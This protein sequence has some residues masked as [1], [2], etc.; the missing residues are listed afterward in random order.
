[1]RYAPYVATFGEYADA[2][3]LAGLA[4]DAEE[5]GW[6]GFF[7]WD[8]MAMWWD[9]ASPVVDSWVALAAI[10]GATSTIRIGALVTPVPRRR[11]WKLARES[12]SID[13]LS[14]GRLVFGAGLGANRHEF[15]ELGEVTGLGERAA[16]LDEGLE[17]LTR[18]WSGE[19]VHHEGRHYRVDGARFLPIPVQQPRI[20]VWVAVSWPNPG[21]MERALGWDGA[22]V[23]V[24]ED[25]PFNTSPEALEG[26]RAAA[27]DRPFDLAVAN[28]NPEWDVDRDAA[29][30]ERYAGAGL[31]WWL[32]VVDPWRFTDDIDRPWPREAM[33]DRILAGPPRFH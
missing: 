8:H 6:D 24:A 28:G 15:E 25:G 29:E 12:V 30:V 20:P 9:R 13:R 18:L 2:A 19:T 14:G 10:A 16:M 4:A 33:R 27:G 17:V 7:I 21:P 23:M 5:A 11:P 22:V 3:V 26:L 32:E 31:T 1:M